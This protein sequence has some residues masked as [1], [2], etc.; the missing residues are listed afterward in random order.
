[1]TDQLGHAR[2]THVRDGH[3]FVSCTGAAIVS[4]FDRDSHVVA[5]GDVAAV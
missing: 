1:M 2:L 5:Y 4:V 3:P